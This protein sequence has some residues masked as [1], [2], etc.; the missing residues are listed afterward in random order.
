[1]M[2]RLLMICLLIAIIPVQRTGAQTDQRCFAETGFCISGRIRAFWEANGGLPVFG[3]PI[4]SQAEATIEG[5]RLQVQPFER[6]R[7]ELHPENTRPFDVLLGRLGADRLVQLGRDWQAAPKE[8]PQA[9]CR[10]FGETGFNV[11]GDLLAAWRASGI[12]IDGR[13]GKTEAEN[14][15]LFGLPLT[16]LTTET[17]SDGKPYQVQYF[18]RA[19]FELHPENAPP[20]NVLLGLLG[21]EPGTA[22]Q[23]QPPAP[24][25]PPVAR[26]LP[27]PTFNACQPDPNPDAAPNSPVQ[28]VAINK[29]T[30][31]VTLKNVSGEPVSLAGWHMCSI[32]GNQEH[33]LDG[34]TL[35][36]GEQRNFTGPSGTIWNN[37]EQDDGALYN[38]NGQLVSYLKD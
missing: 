34:S 25:P 8:T 3:L 6:N 30:E 5:A 21:R 11:C 20:F 1:M 38:Q 18:E 29:Q 22:P 16:G 32:R 28:I 10:F 35:A 37:T 4:G 27:A 12:E 13:V 26:P 19:R 2:Y 33:P 31:V 15:A 9:G 23:V 14:L 7:L 17:L 24:V 36:P